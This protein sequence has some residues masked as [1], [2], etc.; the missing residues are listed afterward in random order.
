V[1]YYDEGGEEMAAALAVGTFVEA[2]AADVQI[3]VI[4]DQTFYFDGTN[5]YQVCYLGIDSGYCVVPDPY[6]NN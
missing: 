6:D 4:G 5:Y 3:L 2:L 1:P